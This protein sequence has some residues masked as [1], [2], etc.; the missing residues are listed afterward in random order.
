MSFRIIA[1]ENDLAFAYI[2]G[3]PHSG[4]PNYS[5]TDDFESQYIVEFETHDAAE[6]RIRKYDLKSSETCEYKVIEWITEKD[7]IRLRNNFHVSSLD[8]IHSMTPDVNGYNLD[9]MRK[10]LGNH[11]KHVQ[12]LIDSLGR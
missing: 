11:M 9:F 8:V 1:L 4:S 10:S 2:E 6:A 3:N 12:R 7:F 5:F